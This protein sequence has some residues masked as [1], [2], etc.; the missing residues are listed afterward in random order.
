MLAGKPGLVPILHLNR[1]TLETNV[2]GGSIM[3]N[4]VHNHRLLPVYIHFGP[5]AS[6]T[7]HT[8]VAVWVPFPQYPVT[9]LRAMSTWTEWSITKS[10]GHTGLITSGLPPSRSTA[11]LIAAKST[12]AGTP[13]VEIKLA[14][15]RTCTPEP[16]YQDCP[17]Y[18]TGNQYELWGSF[19]TQVVFL[20]FHF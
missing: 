7:I 2:N 12:T 15:D 1:R 3:N 9:H 11:S 16:K 20:W 13:P 19:N 8:I 6:T 14:I 5:H 17:Q 18:E 4:T 10:T